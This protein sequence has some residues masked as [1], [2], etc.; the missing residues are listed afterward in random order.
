MT[1]DDDLSVLSGWT[2]DE[3]L[4]D[5]V[6]ADGRPV[7][8]GRPRGARAD[9]ARRAPQRAQPA[10]D[11]VDRRRPGVEPPAR[12][13][14]LGLQ[15]H[16]GQ[17]ARGALRPRLRRARRRRRG[18]QRRVRRPVRAARHRARRR[19]RGDVAPAA[20]AL[21]D[22]LAERT[23]EATSK[24][25]VEL[26]ATHRRD[27][28]PSCRTSSC[29]ARTAPTTCGS[30]ST[31]VQTEWGGE[32]DVE[33][34][35]ARA[36]AGAV[37]PAPAA[38]AGG[39]RR[40]TTA[41]SPRRPAGGCRPT[42]RRRRSCRQS[43]GRRGSARLCGNRAIPERMLV[44]SARNVVAIHAADDRIRPRGFI[45]DSAAGPTTTRLVLY[46]RPVGE[47]ECSGPGPRS[48]LGRGSGLNERAIH[49]RRCCRSGAGVV[50]SNLLRRVTSSDKGYRRMPHRHVA[51]AGRRAL[52]RGLFGVPPTM[53]VSDAERGVP[54]AVRGAD[55][56]DRRRLGG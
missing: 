44:A 45:D 27:R 1:T 55:R 33:R 54:G 38:G 8:R 39:R 43:R 16:A 19:P 15:A 29:A 35:R 56:G 51:R 50:P 12:V 5:G 53:A 20:A 48:S 52:V 37:D 6:R 32:P 30:S 31:R 7:R 17:A 23:D 40:R 9:R 21:R 14:G 46:E 22:N 36:A 24:A 49:E 41:R 18:V 34:T 26:R 42:P 28:R 4:Q 2:D 3:I 10:Q 13:L 25:A 47:L 11:A